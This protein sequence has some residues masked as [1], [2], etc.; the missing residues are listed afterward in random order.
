MSPSPAATL[1][2]AYF[3]GPRSENETWVRGEFQ[4]VLDQWFDW[5]KGLFAG[6][7]GSAS[8]AD[9]LSPERLRK[10]EELSQHLAELCEALTAETPTH[11]PRYIGH[12]KAEVSLPALF[13]WLAAMLHNPNNTSRESSR[14]GSVI[15]AEAV[16]MLATMVGYDPVRA[17]GHFTSGGT[18]AN[19]EAVWR[20]RYRLDHWLSMG[21]HVAE[22]TGD[23]L[24]P[25]AAAHMGWDRFRELWF[26]HDLTDDQLRACSAAV[27]NPASVW[28]RISEAARREYLGPVML[29]PGNKHYSWLKA[30]NLFGLG[31]DSL[32][33]IALDAEGRLDVDDFERLTRLA[34]S[35]GRPVLMTVGVAGATETGGIDPI[36]RLHDRLDRWRDDRERHIWR[37]VDAAYGGFL[38]SLLG[39]ADEKHLS[40]D[41]A[42][43]LRAIATADSVTIDPHKLGY[44]PY[45]CGA[46]LTRDT[47]SYAVSAF[48][49]PYLDRPEL[50][51]GKWSSTME[52]SR[53]ASGAA[54]TWLTG[55]S[56]GFGPE[57]LGA[58][59]AETIRTR[60]AFQA[61]VVEALPCIRFVDPA[62]SNI[63]CFS[64]ADDGESLASANTRTE[65][66]FNVIHQSP[67]FSVSKTTLGPEY[68][69]LIARHTERY[70]GT[71][72]APGL[73]L[74]RCVFM[75]PYW[76]AP[77][78]R[79]VLFPQFIAL[80]RQALAG[81]TDRPP[82]TDPR[83]TEAV[84]RTEMLDCCGLD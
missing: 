74:I 42:A 30:A 39:G 15:E 63:A 47:A 66:L 26:D 54:A 36:H 46:F 75:N 48:D 76:A 3:P 29:V 83:N 84:E 14:V 81:K 70:G 12:M 35:Q 9:R 79:E 4:T 71:A 65:A 6:D 28:R 8:A 67:E 69:A 45:A 31:E 60:A 24:D 20:A 80:V 2:G 44:V 21:L 72:D 41:S 17:Q 22:A 62:D 64:V 10:R 49:A 37:H 13:G 11:T 40:P 82:A 58:V 23:V 78:F 34:E 7:P 43:A 68:Q 19:F 38:C 51:D 32:W 33:S 16:A 27:G 18:V 52:G 73:F 55:R 59:L 50:G 77:D 53:S 25:F 56:L 1:A 57:G 5:R 61:A